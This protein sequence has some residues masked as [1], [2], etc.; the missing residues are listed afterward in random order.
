MF[1]IPTVISTIADLITIIDMA[2]KYGGFLSKDVRN[3]F[4][5]SRDEII[6]SPQSLSIDDAKGILGKQILAGIPKE[7]SAVFTKSIGSYLEIIDGTIKHFEDFNRLEKIVEYGNV[8]ADLIR[9]IGERLNKWGCFEK[10]AEK[11]DFMTPYSP[12]SP[13]RMIQSVLSTPKLSR[14]FWDNRNLKNLV[15]RNLRN[16]GLGLLKTI[17][18]D[19]VKVT[20]ATTLGLVL[21][22]NKKYYNRG[23]YQE[24]VYAHMDA[25]GH[26][27]SIYD[28]GNHN[29]VNVKLSN[30]EYLSLISAVLSDFFDYA[31]RV[32]REY[33]M[34]TNVISELKNN[35][36]AG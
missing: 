8:Y 31:I 24:L 4:E 7:D 10:W 34:S 9:R 1:V 19:S 32:N 22:T 29:Y 12:T 17:T 25:L 23:F 20:N 16:H 33:A 28:S 18:V 3:V 14:V 30:A 27:L 21:I 6:S 36:N 35:K 2:L 26:E 15:D 13:V 5:K 11:I